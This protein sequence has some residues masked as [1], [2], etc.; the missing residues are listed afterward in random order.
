LLLP[1]SDFSMLLTGLSFSTTMPEI[2]KTD[3]LGAVVIKLTAKMNYSQWLPTV[4]ELFVRWE[5]ARNVE[6]PPIPVVVM[7]PGAVLDRFRL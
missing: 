1:F 6:H 7:A 2:F 4:F 5:M 3:F